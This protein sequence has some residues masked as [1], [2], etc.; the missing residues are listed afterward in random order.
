MTMLDVLFAHPQVHAFTNWDFTDGAW[1]GAPAGLVRKDGSTK[2][3]Y[4]ALK[5]KVK[6]D[7][8]TSLTVQTDEHG[9]VEFEGFLG[10]YVLAFE[11]KELRFTLEKDVPCTEMT[12]R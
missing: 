6:K 4:E 12:V 9:K 10:E 3:A 11:G 5:E 7:W 1:L 8:H 2:P